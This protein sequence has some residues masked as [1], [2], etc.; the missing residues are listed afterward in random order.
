MFILAKER[1]VDYSKALSESL[2]TLIS[3]ELLEL[4]EK[5]SVI[6]TSVG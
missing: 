4:E 2:L 6:L 5:Y 1:N 3:M